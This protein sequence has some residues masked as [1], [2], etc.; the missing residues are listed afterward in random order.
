MYSQYCRIESAA[1]G[2][3]CTPKEFI[4]AAHKCLKKSGRSRK[5]RE[6]RHTWLREGLALRIDARVTYRQYA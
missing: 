3:S 5:Q 4:K 1:G 2:V 6:A